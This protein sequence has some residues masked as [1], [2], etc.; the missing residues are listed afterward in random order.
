MYSK[1]QSESHPD[2]AHSR[3]KRYQSGHKWL[4]P[5]EQCV[6]ASSGASTL[7]N[8]LSVRQTLLPDNNGKQKGALITSASSTITFSPP[9]PHPVQQLFMVHRAIFFFFRHCY[10]V[11]HFCRRCQLSLVS[12]VHTNLNT[13]ALPA[14]ISFKHCLVVFAWLTK[15]KSWDISLDIIVCCYISFL[16]FNGYDAILLLVIW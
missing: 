1:G 2:P 13:C 3:H 8:S 4:P 5:T 16:C 11:P 9:C 12:L 14:G 10:D 7:S 6:S 15:E